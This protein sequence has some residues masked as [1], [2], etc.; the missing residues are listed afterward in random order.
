MSDVI[1]DNDR[2][3]SSEI[4]QHVYF[5]YEENPENLLKAVIKF[6]AGKLTGT[7]LSLQIYWSSVPSASLCCDGYSITRGK[8]AGDRFEL[9]EKDVLEMRV[10]R[11]DASGKMSERKL[12]NCLW[13]SP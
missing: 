13:M 10:R 4:L 5:R 3:M 2:L 7:I 9:T 1:E 8:W 6:S 12:S 11:K